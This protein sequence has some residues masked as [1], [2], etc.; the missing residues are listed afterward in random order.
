MLVNN[1]KNLTKI[2]K[3]IRKVLAQQLKDSRALEH[4]KLVYSNSSVMSILHFSIPMAE[5]NV[6]YLGQLA[7]SYKQSGFGPTQVTRLLHKPWVDGNDHG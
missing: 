7:H 2:D 4:F 5:G 1:G 3:T 6:R